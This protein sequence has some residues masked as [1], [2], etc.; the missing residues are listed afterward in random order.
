[1]LRNKKINIYK[2]LKGN[3]LKNFI[4]FSSSPSNQLDP[5]IVLLLVESLYINIKQNDKIIHSKNCPAYLA[6]L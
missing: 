1:M 3:V 6:R 5:T 2:K 4:R